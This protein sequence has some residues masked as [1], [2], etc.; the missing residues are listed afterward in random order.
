[1]EHTLIECSAWIE[2]KA[3]L[4]AAMGMNTSLPSVVVTIVDGEIDVKWRAFSSF[5]ESHLAEGGDRKRET[6]KE[7]KNPSFS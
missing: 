6:W 1:M 4:V 2:E 7:R 3:A 5:C